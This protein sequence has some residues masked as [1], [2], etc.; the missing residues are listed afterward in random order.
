MRNLLLLCLCLP[1]IVWAQKS[2]KVGPKE[3][4]YSIGRLYN[5]HPRELAQ[6]NGLTISDGLKIDQV[7]KIPAKTTMAPLP[8]TPPTPSTPTAP[9][10]EVVKSKP[11]ENKKSKSNPI[12]H[13]VQKKETL[14]QIKRTYPGVSIDDLKK[15]NKLESDGL[16][17]GMKLIVGYTSSD[18]TTQTN[19]TVIN[20]KSEPIASEQ[21]VV[22]QP[23][24]NQPEKTVAEK[25]QNVEANK[26]LETPKKNDATKQNTEVPV[27]ETVKT[28]SAVKGDGYFK[29]QF[30]QRAAMNQESGTAGAFKSTSGWED[31]KYYCLHNSASAGTIMQITNPLNGK[32]IFAKVLDVIP[33]IPQNKGLV[34]RLSNASASALGVDKE[35]FEV[36]LVY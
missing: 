33:D 34:V 10:V 36:N 26:L 32:S 31:G 9:I 8:S 27:Q 6:F 22:E 15:W 20:A 35:R 28:A 12:Y 3:T 4:I 23:K 2:H 16:S 17:E 25:P 24:N 5:I 14:F 30:N 18:N 29:S 7:L 11:V 21:V 19:T 1:T 13:T